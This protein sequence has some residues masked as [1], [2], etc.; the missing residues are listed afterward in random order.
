MQFPFPSAPPPPPAVRREQAR[1]CIGVGQASL[2]PCR[3]HRRLSTALV[4]RAA[5][6]FF[7]TAG[8]KVLAQ[9]PPRHLG[10]EQLN[11]VVAPDADTDDAPI[12][13]REGE[14]AARRSCSGFVFFFFFA[15]GTATAS[16]RSSTKAAK[17]TSSAS[18]LAA[19]PLVWGPK[20]EP[21][22]PGEEGP[23]LCHSFRPLSRLSHL[24]LL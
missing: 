19:P 3:C 12:A 13:V 21:H 7:T 24:I 5:P 1:N 4:L 8:A 16:E 17:K 15:S 18:S 14:A 20:S 23:A 22:R 6:G 10:Q 9:R 2:S 11:Q